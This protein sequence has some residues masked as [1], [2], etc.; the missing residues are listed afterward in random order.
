MSA[1]IVM[2]YGTLGGTLVE[3]IMISVGMMVGVSDQLRHSCV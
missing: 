3:M 2:V 1:S